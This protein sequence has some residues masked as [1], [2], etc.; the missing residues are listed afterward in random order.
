MALVDPNLPPPPPLGQEE[1]P[2]Y[3]AL[4]IAKNQ[5]I[6]QTQEEYKI[7]SLQL[8]EAVR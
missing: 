6:N 5:L 1:N 2:P 3:P 4:A 8:T 7:N